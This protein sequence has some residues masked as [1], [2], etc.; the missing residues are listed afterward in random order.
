M[1]LLFLFLTVSFI[2]QICDKIEKLAARLNV[3]FQAVINKLKE[4]FANGVSIAT[5]PLKIVKWIWQQFFGQV[6]DMVAKRSLES[7]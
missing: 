4:W 1:F 5:M 3:R 6:Y 7:M 2:V